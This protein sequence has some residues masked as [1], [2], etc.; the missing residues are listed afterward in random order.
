MASNCGLAIILNGSRVGTTNNHIER[1]LSPET[2]RWSWA[3]RCRPLV[4]TTVDGAD[5]VAHVARSQ[6]PS[7][8]VVTSLSPLHLA[9]PGTR[10]ITT[11]RPLTVRAMP[12]PPFHLLL[13]VHRRLRP[14]RLRRPL[15]VRRPP[16]PDIPTRVHRFR[17]RLRTHRRRQ[18]R[19]AGTSPLHH[20]RLRLNIL[21]AL[22]QSRPS[23]RVIPTMRPLTLAPPDGHRHHRRHLRP[24]RH[25]HLR[26]RGAFRP[27]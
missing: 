27:G 4:A 7:M 14:F 6:G 23:S 2:P 11:N 1:E 18:L 25:R 9:H 5:P 3:G 24:C 26:A 16:V 20:F 12:L 21:P 13:R 22:S 17:S 15:S 19:R 8:E 10:T